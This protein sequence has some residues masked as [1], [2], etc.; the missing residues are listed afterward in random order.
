M[1]SSDERAIRCCPPRLIRVRAALRRGLYSHTFVALRHY[2][3]RLFWSARLVTL[4]GSWMQRVALGW[5][6]LQLTNSPLLLGVVS[7]AGAV[8]VILLGL[9]AG[10]AVDRVDKRRLVLA[11]QTAFMFLALTLAILT[12]SGH[13]RVWHVI[14]IVMLTGVVNAYD[15]PARQAMIIDLAG[16]VDLT[17]AVALNSAAFN[18]ARIIGPSLAGLLI[19]RVGIAGCFFLS[20]FSFLTI[21][22]ALAVMRLDA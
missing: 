15:G 13:I 22:T 2:N 3:F 11:T 18:A 5:L 16:R 17:N 21:I 8:P 12:A 9:F 7:F 4:I 10:V 20:G 14:A 19:A 1:R 6:V